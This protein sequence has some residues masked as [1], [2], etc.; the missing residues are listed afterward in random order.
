MRIL[1]QILMCPPSYFGVNYEINPWM[2][3]NQ[4]PDFKKAQEQWKALYT[5]LKGWGLQ[6]HLIEAK[7]NLP[8]MVFTA[9]GG[10]IIEGKAILTQFKHQER[11]GEMEFFKKYFEQLGLEIISL[12]GNY[13]FEGEGDALFFKNSLIAGY[14]SRSDIHV[15]QEISKIMDR[16]VI[17]VELVSPDF[18][19]LDTCFCPLDDQ[20]AFYY[21]GAFDEYGQKALKRLI[22]NLIEVSQEDASSFCCNAVIV[23]K[24]IVLN[25]CSKKLQ[26]ALHDL[27]YSP[28]CLEFDQFIKA[29]GSGKCM[30]L[31]LG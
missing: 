27:G 26:S 24:N 23:G 1:K 18:Y 17:S 3:K 14:R 6:I 28:H 30:V 31:S 7:P 2:H 20:N 5:T 19:H 16:P 22:P 8:D 11:Q 9:N 25:R 29:G 15:H 13:S 10:L 12:Q 21:P 4:P